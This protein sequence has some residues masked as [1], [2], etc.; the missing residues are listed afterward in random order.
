M[1][2]AQALL[3]FGREA[4]LNLVRSWRISLLAVLTIAVSLFLAGC[5]ALASTNLTELIDQ[6]RDN[7][8]VVVYL[9]HSSTDDDLERLRELCA[10]TPW[11][12]SVDTV[13]ADQA[14]QRF[15][16]AFPSMADLV[17]SGENS[18]PP[19]LEIQ[20]AWQKLDP[21]ILDPWLQTLRN[22]PVV[23]QI[24]DDRDWLRQVRTVVLVLRG[25]G[26]LV[27]SVLLITAVFTISS[28]IRLTA[29]LYRD[30]I[31]VMRQVGATEFFIRGPFY[32][33]GLIQGF[34]GGAVAL[35]SLFAAHQ[36]LIRQPA[37]LLTSLTRDFLPLGQGV[38][39]IAAGAIAGLIGAIT[40]LRRESLDQQEEQV[41]EWS[42]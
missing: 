28:V 32:A 22:D 27:G 8:R 37:S 29:Y 10:Q 16:K 33:E 36:L 20:A 18:L 30:E 14:R 19:S 9:D 26:L 6:W 23:A 12:E 24:D 1:T 38:L 41:A 5:F 3:Y 7:A 2:L 11:I 17:E 4:C 34:L 35:L 31:A 39:L 42:P 13:D 15:Q 40:S 25:L 21:N